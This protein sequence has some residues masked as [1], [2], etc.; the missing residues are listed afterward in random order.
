MSEDRHYIK[1]G[2]LHAADGTFICTIPPNAD[3]PEPTWEKWLKDPENTTFKFYGNNLM[4]V[5]YK[6][7]RKARHGK[8]SKPGTYWYAHHRIDGRLKHLSCGS[9]RYAHN[10][11]MRK[12]NHIANKLAKIQLGNDLDRESRAAWLPRPQA[13]RSGEPPRRIMPTEPTPAAVQTSLFDAAPEET[14][15][16][17]DD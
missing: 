1:N 2:N 4:F 6:E 15:G 3:E 14:R 10:I 11:T 13:R 12:L 8:N 17:Y 7:H 16:Y 5:A 9:I